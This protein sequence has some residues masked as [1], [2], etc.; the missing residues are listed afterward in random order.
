M[1]V[2]QF[3]RKPPDEN[4]RRGK[5]NE[6]VYSERG[7]SDALGCDTCPDGDRSLKGNPCNGEDFET[8]R[9]RD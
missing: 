9:L 3:D 5:L 8:E 2:F 6:T 7:E 4:D 1:A